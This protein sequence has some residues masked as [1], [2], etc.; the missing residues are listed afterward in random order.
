MA[1]STCE[2]SLRKGKPDRKIRFS[3]KDVRSCVP[4]VHCRMLYFGVRDMRAGTREM[5]GRMPDLKGGIRDKRGEMGTER[6]TQK[7]GA[8]ND[9]SKRPGSTSRFE[10]SSLA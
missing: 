4:A 10:P 6:T 2:R 8:K 5:R 9:R 3:C 7:V 1:L